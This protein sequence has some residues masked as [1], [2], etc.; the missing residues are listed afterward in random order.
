[1][2]VGCGRSW[3]ARREVKCDDYRRSQMPAALSVRST[4]SPTRRTAATRSPSCSTPTGSTTEEMQQFARWTNLSETTFVLP[5]TQPEADYRVRIFT[6]A[7]ELPFA[8]HP[9]LGTCHAWLEAGARRRG[10]RRAG[11]RRRARAH[12]PHDDGPR[13]RRAAAAPFGPVDEARRADRHVL[14]IPRARSSPRSGPTTARVGRRVCC[15]ARA[16][17]LR[18]RAGRRQGPRPRRRRRRRRPRR[19]A[20]VLPARRRDRRG[21]RD[22]EPQRERRALA[23]RDRPGRA[24]VRRRRRRPARV[25]VSEDD[26]GAL[27]IGGG[28][29]TCIRGEV[30]A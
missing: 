16:A 5:P 19:A 9:T 10:R 27:W 2:R 20:G 28:T 22:R 7:R 18:P 21:P 12:P 17:V 6:P 30:V 24:A 3:S 8:G 13:V 23:A 4:C 25:H 15:G 1:M 11:V 26:H 14:L 29:V